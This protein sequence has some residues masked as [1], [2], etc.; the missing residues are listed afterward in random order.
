ML[1]RTLAGM[2]EI[3]AH[4]EQ[5]GIFGNG[6]IEYVEFESWFLATELCRAQSSA[7]LLHGM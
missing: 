6:L 7:E 5:G 2:N 4:S 3:D 1:S